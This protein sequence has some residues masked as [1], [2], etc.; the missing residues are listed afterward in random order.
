MAKFVAILIAV[1]LILLVAAAL[2]LP[3]L[4]S[5]QRVLDLAS[6]TIKEKTGATLIVNGGANFSIF[7][8]ISVE[9]EDTGIEFPGEQSISATARSLG[10]YN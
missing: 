3:L 6:Q 2:L 4:V 5:E 7:P 8:S 10:T 1:P 9:V